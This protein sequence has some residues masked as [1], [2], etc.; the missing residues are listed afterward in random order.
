MI[1]QPDRRVRCFPEYLH[2]KVLCFLERPCLLWVQVWYWQNPRRPLRLLHLGRPYLKP[3]QQHQLHQPHQ[4]DLFFQ[5]L[6][7]L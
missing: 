1:S 5:P 2:Q 3:N 7:D 6:M 4:L